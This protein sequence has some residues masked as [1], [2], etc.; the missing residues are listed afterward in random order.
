MPS[1]SNS[2]RAFLGPRPG[3]RVSSTSPTGYFARSFSAAGIVPVSSSDMILSSSVA[4]IPGSWVTL[5]SR[6]RAATE[7]GASRTDLAALR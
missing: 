1:S 7:R 3:S 2:L 6:A 4:P 5:P